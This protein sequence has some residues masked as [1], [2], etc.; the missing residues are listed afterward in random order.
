MV[1]SSSSAMSTLMED[2]ERKE[3]AHGTL[4]ATHPLQLLPF[5][6]LHH[7]YPTMLFGNGSPCDTFLG[8]DAM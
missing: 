3:A 1:S 5:K 7:D 4:S 8:G 6:A 2:I